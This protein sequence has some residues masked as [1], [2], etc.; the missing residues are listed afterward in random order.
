[1]SL[2]VKLCGIRTESDIA[3]AMNA[4]ANAVGFVLTPS[5]RRVEL[6]E[7]ARLAALIRHEMVTVAVFHRPGPRLLAETREVLDPDLYQAEP[8]ALVG[9]PADR[10]LP[11]V[12]DGFGL[13]ERVGEALER[14]ERGMVLVDRTAWGGTGRSPDWD[15]VAALES[16][17]RV[18]LAGGLTP[19][20]VAEAVCRVRPLGVDVS[21]GIE[22]APGEKDPRLMIGFVAAAR[23]ALERGEAVR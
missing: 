21:S 22:Q 4:G 19:D 15:R 17:D 8:H 2:F 11:V 3:A 12:V 5:P 1:M 9:V 13:G 23:A 16:R 10:M 20:N 6:S 18:I 7:A 14:A